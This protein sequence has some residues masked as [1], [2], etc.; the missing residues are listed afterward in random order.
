VGNDLA[1]WQQKKKKTLT[2]ESFQVCGYFFPTLESVERHLVSRHYQEA[3]KLDML[4]NTR[5]LQQVSVGH[6]WQILF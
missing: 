5:P 6:H 3:L 4:Q 1:R 2:P